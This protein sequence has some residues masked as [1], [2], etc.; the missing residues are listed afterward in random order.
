L[1]GLDNL[2]AAVTKADWFD[3]ELSPKFAAF[4]RHYRITPMTCCPYSPQHK[5]KVERSVQHVRH[6]ALA[7]REFANLSVLNAH[8]RQWEQTVADTRIH[9]TTRRQVGEHFTTVEKPA[10]KPLPQELF[11]A[12]TETKRR[13]GRDGYVEVVKAYYQ[14][15]PEHIGRSVGASRWQAGAPLQRRDGADRQ[16]HADRAGTLQQCA[17]SARAGSRG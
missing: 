15:P 13:V 7:G 4:C 5:G 1:A 6:N 9:G 17:R 8:L 2:K 14:A 3:P 10:L 16:P 12:F 11:P